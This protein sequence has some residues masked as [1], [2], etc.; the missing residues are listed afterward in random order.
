MAF[1]EK[2]KSKVG[3]Y[4]KKYTST[5][6]SSADN[7]PL[8]GPRIPPQDLEAEKALLGSILL[9]PD[10]MFDVIDVVTRNSFYAEKHAMI[11]DAIEDLMHRKEPVDLLTVTGKLRDKKELEQVGGA[12]YL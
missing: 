5:S 11:F 3:E 8:R 12:P 6:T 9:S 7:D 1:Q 4:K 2:S 10:S